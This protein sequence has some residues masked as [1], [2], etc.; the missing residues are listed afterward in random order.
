[1]RLCYLAGSYPPVRM[2]IPVPEVGYPRL[3]APFATFPQGCPRV[4]VRLACLIHAANVR[5]E[6]GSNP[7]KFL[8]F[9]RT[10]RTRS[11]TLPARQAKALSSRP[12]LRGR[13]WVGNRSL[14]SLTVALRHDSKNCLRRFASSQRVHVSRR[15]AHTSLALACRCYRIVKDQTKTQQGSVV[16][17]LTRRNFAATSLDTGFPKEDSPVSNFRRVDLVS[18]APRH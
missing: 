17:G 12:P 3:T 14:K 5:S 9:L 16:S 11:L 8:A 6:P 4:L 10:R 15:K 7:S 13:P 2:A 1:M 18:A